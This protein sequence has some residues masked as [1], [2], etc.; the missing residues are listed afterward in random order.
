[1][2]TCQRLLLLRHV[3]VRMR[4]CQCLIFWVFV[5][6]DINRQTTVIILVWRT[7]LSP[8]WKSDGGESLVTIDTAA[9]TAGLQLRFQRHSFLSY[10]GYDTRARRGLCMLWE[11]H[12][13]W[14]NVLHQQWMP[15]IVSDTVL[16][17]PYF[18]TSS[19]SSTF[20]DWYKATGS[21]L[22]RSYHVPLFDQ[23]M[24]ADSPF[25][26]KEVTWSCIKDNSGEITRTIDG[27]PL[28]IMSKV[29]G[30]QA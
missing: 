29:H 17:V 24:L 19:S 6:N 3:N 23:H 18:S 25:V 1:M 10:H 13:S 12:I 14:H 16:K 27:S 8:F 11:R 15:L 22:L 4:I 30:R 9:C 28:P 7:N 21:T 26:R 20:Q 5:A 2:L